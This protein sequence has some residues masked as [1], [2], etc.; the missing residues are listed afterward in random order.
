MIN[1][2]NPDNISGFFIQYKEICNISFALLQQF[3]DECHVTQ[4]RRLCAGFVGLLWNGSCFHYLNS[5]GYKSSTLIG[6]PDSID[7]FAA[8]PMPMDMMPSLTPAA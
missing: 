8:M 3:A 7:L 2:K 1:N 6:K 5:S 4:S